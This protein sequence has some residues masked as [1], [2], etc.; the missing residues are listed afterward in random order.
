M[1]WKVIQKIRITVILM[2]TNVLKHKD[3]KEEEK[4]IGFPDGGD[5]PC[6][7]LPPHCSFMMK[8]TQEATSDEP[9]D[10]QL[11]RPIPPHALPTTAHG[12]SS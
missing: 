10:L 6:V 3:L 9:W 8:E 5:R 7:I 12:L 1:N 4:H 11:R 2:I